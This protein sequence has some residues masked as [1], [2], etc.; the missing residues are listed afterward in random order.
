METTTTLLDPLS[1]FQLL[2]SAMAAAVAVEA[3][4]SKSWTGGGITLVF[5]AL[6][7][8][9]QPISAKFPVIGAAFSEIGSSAV[10]WWIIIV[11]GVAIWLARNGKNKTE[12]PQ[13]IVGNSAKD[14]IPNLTEVEVREIVQNETS[15]GM[16]QI[17][18]SLSAIRLEMDF[19]PPLREAVNQR[20]SKLD[21]FKAVLTKAIENIYIDDVIGYI[22]DLLENKV[23]APAMGIGTRRNPESRA[24]ANRNA[25]LSQLELLGVER[26]HERIDERQKSINYSNQAFSTD[27]EKE[28]WIRDRATEALIP[29]FIEEAERRKATASEILRQINIEKTK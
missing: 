28:V 17:R 22:N 23:D 3:W 18:E 2:A 9:T 10:S 26:I 19:L 13:L 1:A 8:F 15:A 12:Q 29:Q 5:A 7:I 27:A 6:A 21:S 11:A 14:E 25:A 24:R 20:F 4:R 16:D